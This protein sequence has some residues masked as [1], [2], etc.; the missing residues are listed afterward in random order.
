M[1]GIIDSNLLK[2]L[3]FFFLSPGSKYTRIEVKKFVKMNNVVL[4]ESLA[5]L[6]NSNFLSRKK[7][8]YFLNLE[9]FFVNSLLEK[10]KK[11]FLGLPL[12]IQ[13]LLIDF[14]FNLKK[15]Q[16][17]EQVIL[18]GSY[19]KLIFSKN[20]DI[21]LAIISR[22]GFEKKSSKNKILKI[23]NLIHKKH[24]KKIEEH[25]F[26]ES[27]LKEKKDPLI[28]EILKNGRELFL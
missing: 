14:I 16:G 1:I 22:K 19:S 26:L 4:D 10:W 28:K 23:S 3:F 17:V 12:D 13:F 27:D 21:D 2:I 5:R 8:L 20:S 24:G 6:V 15:I 7:S 25:F 11:S 9:N 18:F